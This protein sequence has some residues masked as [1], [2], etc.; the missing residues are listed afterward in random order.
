MEPTLSSQQLNEI[1]QSLSSGTFLYET[2]MQKLM[3]AGYDE[4]SGRNLLF[5]LAKEHRKEL[6]QQTL[7][8]QK[9][10]GAREITWLVVIMTAAVGPVFEITSAIWYM[11]AMLIASVAGYYGFKTKPV[12]GIIGCILVVFLFPFTYRY[13]FSGRER[14]IRIELLIPLFLSLIPAAIAGFIFLQIFYTATK[15][16]SY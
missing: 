2:E 8:K 3:Q 12:A 13:Y 10:D 1:R 5:T 15:K 6:F 9:N 14:Y 16:N 4:E 11:L 7:Q